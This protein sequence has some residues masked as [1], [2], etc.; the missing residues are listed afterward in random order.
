MMD[1]DYP[2]GSLIEIHRRFQNDTL[3][4]KSP[5]SCIVECERGLRTR[6]AS[7]LLTP[8]NPATGSMPL[9]SPR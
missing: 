9:G 5:V 7:P 2:A 6:P 4:P 3:L 1:H 8:T